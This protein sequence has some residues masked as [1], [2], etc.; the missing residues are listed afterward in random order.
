MFFVALSMISGL[1]VAA[2]A[3]TPEAV[4]KNLHIYDVIGN[5]YV[6][7]PSHGCAGGRY[8]LSPS[9]AKYDAIF[10]VLM[11]A[12]IAERKVIVRFD[13]CSTHASPQ[14][15]IIGVYLK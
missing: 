12:Q 5:A 3:N 7:L 9:H 6:D 13:S 10:S 14:G 11:A 2:P 4:P 8:K 15:Y 1:A